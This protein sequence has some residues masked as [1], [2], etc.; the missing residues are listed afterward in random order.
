MEDLLTEK[1][2]SFLEFQ[3]AI[4]DCD[5]AKSAADKAQKDLVDTRSMLNKRQTE[6]QMLRGMLSPDSFVIFYFQ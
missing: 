1:K 5:A 6:L 2:N 4:D 3:K